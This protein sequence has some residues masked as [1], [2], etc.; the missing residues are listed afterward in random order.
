MFHP[1]LFHFNISAIPHDE[2]K[3][4]QDE[5]NDRKR[6]SND[7]DE[8]DQS[9][10]KKGGNEGGND[11]PSRKKRRKNFRD[12]RS[13]NSPQTSS[14]KRKSDVED[15]QP[16]RKKKRQKDDSCVN[17]PQ[18]SSLKRKSDVEDDQPSRKKKRQ[19]DDSCVNSPQTSSLKRKS[20]V[21][22]DQP[23]RKKKRQKDDSCV[24]SPQTSKN[25]IEQN[26]ENSRD[27]NTDPVEVKTGGKGNV[28]A[29][30]SGDKDDTIEDTPYERC[31][32]SDTGTG[33]INKDGRR[34]AE[35]S[36]T[37]LLR[38][39]PPDK[40]TFYCTHCPSKFFTHKGLKM[41]VSN[42]HRDRGNIILPDRNMVTEQIY[43]QTTADQCNYMT[44]PEGN[45]MGDIN[46]S[47]GDVSISD[48]TLINNM[49]GD[50]E[51]LS[52]DDIDYTLLNYL[53]EPEKS[54]SIVAGNNPEDDEDDED[55][56]VA[57][58]PVV[59]QSVHENNAIESEQGETGER[60]ISLVLLF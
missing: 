6:K 55:D 60:H 44:K 14:L 5:S 18:T 59:T 28:S 13:V 51:T 52:T 17:S 41:H 12:D 25:D 54:F 34:K 7:K 31:D 32:E 19:K 11:Q 20:D 16:S 37:Y 27:T 49:P 26:V 43:E 40:P 38:I 23:S 50:I 58:V 8:E 30:T 46:I 45:N 57:S 4:R 24:N 35:E 29:E 22:D 15:D 33:I 21:E 9:S 1:K 36:P 10:R 2:E 3:R 56:E 47:F 48:Q 53:P 39:S 42:W